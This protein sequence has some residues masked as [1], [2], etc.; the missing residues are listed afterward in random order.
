MPPGKGP[1]LTQWIPMYEILNRA[2]FDETP[3]PS[4]MAIQTADL[5]GIVHCC[6]WVRQLQSNGFCAV[7]SVPATRRARRALMCA[8]AVRR[9][10]HR[11]LGHSLPRA[12]TRISVRT[13]S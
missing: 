10:P 11:P 7:P 2:S 4:R 8:S 12:A 1:A 5:K 3:M 6:R 13:P 9:R